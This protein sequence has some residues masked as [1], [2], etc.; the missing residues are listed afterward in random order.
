MRV[1]HLTG[2]GHL[3][4]DDADYAFY[5]P[6]SDWKRKEASSESEG[7]YHAVRELRIGNKRLTIR[8]H[9]LIT[10]ARADQRVT[11][12]DGNL[13][14]CQRRNLHLHTLK[15]WTS[16]PDHAGFKGVHQI[17]ASLWKVEIEFAGQKI[18]IDDQCRD[19]MVGA[20]LYDKA[21]RKLY[22]ANATTN[23]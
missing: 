19:P 22:G 6:F 4:V 18:V 23:F 10:E 9:R 17:N 16:R 15:P 5:S 1:I 2:G 3:K 14:N 20:K 8:A 11:A 7:K 21:A 12:L 13:L